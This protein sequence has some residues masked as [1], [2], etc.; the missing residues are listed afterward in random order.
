MLIMS[1]VCRASCR[2]SC[3]GSN[4][5]KGVSGKVVY[6]VPLNN[7]RVSQD[8]LAL[9]RNGLYTFIKLLSKMLGIC[10]WWPQRW[11]WILSGQLDMQTVD[12]S[13][14]WGGMLSIA[15]DAAEARTLIDGTSA[16][17]RPC[18]DCDY[19]VVSAQPK[20][21]WRR[22]CAKGDFAA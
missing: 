4:E 2:E 16:W 14:G 8:G 10:F 11:E 22:M 12:M 13:S 18:V 15:E 7:C 9:N 17:V 3:K 21:T 5:V 6:A 1:R 19:F 20:G